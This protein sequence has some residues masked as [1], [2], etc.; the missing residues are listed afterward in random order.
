VLLL[1]EGED[2]VLRKAYGY[3]DPAK[4]IP[5]DPDRTVIHICSVSKLFTAA[6]EKR[7]TVQADGTLRIRDDVYYPV[8]SLLYRQKDSDKLVAF[9]VGPAGAVTLYEDPTEELHKLRWWETS[10][11]STRLLAACAVLLSSATVPC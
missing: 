2:V 4:K 3:A 7:V 5:M 10:T 8:D 9:R 1:V 6:E 11:F